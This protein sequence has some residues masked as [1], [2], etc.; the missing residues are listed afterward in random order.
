MPALASL[1]D[2]EARLGRT[3]Q[4]ADRARAL[5]VLE[6]ASAWVRAEAGQDWIDDDGALETVPAAVKSVCLSVSRRVFDNPEG[7][8]QESIDGYSYGRTN[9]STDLFLTRQEQRLLRR[10][11][12]QG[13]LSSIELESPWYEDTVVY[14]TI[15]GQPDADPVPWPY[16]PT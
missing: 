5:A 15:Y 7:H 13:G 1:A 12:G 4:E 16:P 8:M 2:F 10:A 6:D 9:A 11:L 14:A 3:L